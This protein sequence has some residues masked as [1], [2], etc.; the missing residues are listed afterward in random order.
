MTPP[1]D[2]SRTGDGRVAAFLEAYEDSPVLELL[3]EA[4]PKAAHPDGYRTGDGGL[5]E[6]AWG[7]AL[8]D[9]MTTALDL[10]VK[11][12]R[13]DDLEAR[14]ARAEAFRDGVADLLKREPIPARPFRDD[15]VTT[16]RGPFTA[17]LDD[18]EYDRD[19]AAWESDAA[20][21]AV[22]REQALRRLLLVGPSRRENPLPP[23]ASRQRDHEGALWDEIAVTV[24]TTP[25]DALR[26]RLPAILA[27]LGRSGEQMAEPSTRRERRLLLNEMLHQRQEALVPDA[28]AGRQGPASPTRAAGRE[29]PAH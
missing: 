18:A 13:L 12:G 28:S 23:N 8:D 26:S 22:R 15:Y 21:A 4:F 9:F 6:D 19:H 10:A 16:V 3:A 11:I 5:D 2:T 14:L 27:Q 24:R 7:E 1:D 17:V 25:D 29:R 20:E